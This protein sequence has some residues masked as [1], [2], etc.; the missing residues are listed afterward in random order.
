MACGNVGINCKN[1]WL[2]RKERKND[3]LTVKAVSSM[4]AINVIKTRILSLYNKEQKITTS[5]IILYEQ[6]LFV[7]AS[8]GQ[9]HQNNKIIE[10]IYSVH[11]YTTLAHIIICIIYGP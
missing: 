3:L 7:L 9:S 8:P 1:L 11:T 2:F 5:E 4:Y 10:H 6:L